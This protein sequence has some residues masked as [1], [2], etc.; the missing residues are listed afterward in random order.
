MQD[1][2]FLSLQNRTR[3]K[4]EYKEEEIQDDMWR[5]KSN[6]KFSGFLDGFLEL[7]GFMEELST[8]PSENQN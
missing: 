3:V 1:D 5:S 7:D 8:V 4:N 6:E 2:E